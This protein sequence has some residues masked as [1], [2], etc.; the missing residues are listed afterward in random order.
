MKIAYIILK[1]VSWGGGIE[2]YTEEVGS[3]LAAKGHKIVVYT[4]RHY[5]EITSYRG[6]RIVPIPTLKTKGL[7]KITASFI[8]TMF[9]IFEKN[10]DIVHFNAFGPAM[11]CFIPRILG[12]KT[13]V[14]GHG[15]EWKRTR[16]GLGGQLFLKLTEIPSVMFPNAITAVSRVQQRYIRKRYGRE[17]TFIPTG[18]NSP[19]LEKPGLIKQYGVNG[20]DYILFAARL[21]QEKGAHYLIEAY[22]NLRTDLKLV[23]AGDA[24]HEEGYKSKL[25]K[26]AEG[27]KN[28]IFTGFATGKLLNELFSNCYLFVLPSEIEGLSTTLLEAMSYGNCCLVSD[29]PEN[30]EAMSESGFSFKNRDI[31]DL[32]ERLQ[33]LINNRVTVESLK[34]KAKN[35]VLENYSWDKITLE[36]EKFYDN[37]LEDS[38]E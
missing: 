4:M 25:Y 38:K 18:I 31:H 19:Q 32:K 27:N 13:V 1:S 11:F 5:S 21:V 30:I 37:L 24:L 22:K 14:Q 9:Q 20:D 7:E 34:E 36:F 29:I 10:I 6:M 12:R 3:R 33:Y 23:I 26:I 28:I 8:A 35:Y 16:W 2:R 17:S 15:L